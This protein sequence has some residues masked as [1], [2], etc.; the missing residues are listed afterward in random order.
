[1]ETQSTAAPASA[2]PASEGAESASGDKPSEAAPTPISEI[3]D[4]SV[5]LGKLKEL[6]S[7]ESGTAPTAPETEAEAEAEGDEEAEAAPEGE[8]QQ[9]EE[10]PLAEGATGKPKGD[11][12]TK[13]EGGRKRVR[14]ITEHLDEQERQ[15]LRHVHDGMTL[16]EAQAKVYGAT[17]AA[18]AQQQQEKIEKK[19]DPENDPIALQRTAVTDIEAELETAEKEF[20]SDKARELRGKLRA[21]ERKL[22]TLEYRAEQETESAQR[23]AAQQHQA[24]VEAAQTSAIESFH[25][26]GFDPDVDEGEPSPL[27][28]AVQDR[29]AVL[30]K[31]NPAY[32]NDPEWPLNLAASEALK[33]GIQPDA[34]QAAAVPV[35]PKPTTPAAKAVAPAQKQPIQKSRPV[36]PAP[37]SSGAAS[38]ETQTPANVDL[39]AEAAEALKDPAKGLEFLRKHGSSI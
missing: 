30:K 6:G 23:A 1:M 7:T 17:G 15:V 37:A 36:A 2:A 32:F 33:L 9:Q 14:V 34:K 31:T 27:F 38:S 18:P 5:L 12:P 16:R 8:A 10:A 22:N 26:L 3:N 21:E 13:P 19:P 4:S 20:D 11:E 28:E 35:K 39:E 24:S 29:I 25:D